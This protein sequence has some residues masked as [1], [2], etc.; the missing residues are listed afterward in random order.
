MYKKIMDKVAQ[1]MSGVK[2]PKM[3]ENHALKILID[4]NHP[5]RREGEKDY[6]PPATPGELNHAK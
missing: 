1:Q 2:I 3:K 4:N 5:H 6:T